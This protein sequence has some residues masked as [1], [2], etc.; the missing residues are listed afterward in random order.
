MV[1]NNFTIVILGIIFI[2]LLPMI[3]AFIKNLL[4]RKKAI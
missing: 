1:K 2:S 3:I 4:E